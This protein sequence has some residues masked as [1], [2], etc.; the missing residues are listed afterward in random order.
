MRRLAVRCAPAA[1]LLGAAVGVAQTGAPVHSAAPSE[2]TAL[3]ASLRQMAAGFHGHLSLYAVDL[4][5]GRFVALDADQPVQTASVIKLAI[6]YEAL[7]QIRAGKAS[8]DEPVMLTHANQTGGSG[9]LQF[10]HTPL[11][12]TLRD[13]LTMMIAE[14]DNTATNVAIDTLGLANIDGE[15]EKLGLRDT[16]LYKKIGVP[17]TAP[18]PADQPRYGLGKTTPREMASFMERFVTCNLGNG[19]VTANAPSAKSLCSAALFM[20]EKQFFRDG[21]PRYL[22]GT[23]VQIANKSGALDHVRNDVGAVWEPKGPIV[24]SVFT[25]G[26]EDTSWTPDNRAELLIARVSKAIVDAWH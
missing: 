10:F 2:D 18:M 6:L 21:L 23:G 12:L 1:L 4:N 7:E 17:A 25:N 13:V 16:W 8:F 3:E 9:V 22:D 14:S 24:L 20:L 15:I 19:P 5:S 11:Q 26:N